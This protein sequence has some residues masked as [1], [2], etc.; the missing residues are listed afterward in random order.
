MNGFGLFLFAIYP[1]A[2]VDLHTDHL[3]VISPLRQLRIFCAGVWHN[4]VLA[5]VAFGIWW[6]LPY[7]LLPLYTTN[8][9]AVVTNVLQVRFS[10]ALLVQI[11]RNKNNKLFNCPQVSNACH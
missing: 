11:I 7:I 3:T 6:F 9:G 8:R 5:L 4:F 10:I 2:F 1:G